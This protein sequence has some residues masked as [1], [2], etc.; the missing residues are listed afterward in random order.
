MQIKVHKICIFHFFVVSL[1]PK[2]NNKVM[3]EK[4]K[5]RLRAIINAGQKEMTADDRAFIRELAKKNGIDIKNT[6]CKDCYFDAAVDLSWQE[7]EKEIGAGAEENDERR[8]IL[9]KGVDLLFGDIRVNAA[10]MTDELAERIIAR[11][12]E[13]KYFEKC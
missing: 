6:R 4:Q 10:T 13:K 3:T 11:G 1:H 12:F 7:K 9:R 5:E 2:Q 8:Y